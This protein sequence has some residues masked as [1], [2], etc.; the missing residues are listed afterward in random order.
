MLHIFIDADACPVKKE[1]Y[2]VADRYGLAVI[3]V[4]NARMR[5]PRKRWIRLEIVGTRFDA[6]DDWI[7][8]HVQPDDI[9]VSADILLA[10]RCL[11]K[12]ARV[13]GPT[14]K[15]FTEDNIGH[16]VAT[17][18]LLAELREAGEIT[19]GPPPMKKRD[20]SRFLQKLDAVIVSI[21]RG[22]ASNSM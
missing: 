20:R 21:R 19:G 8:E 9:V 6:A 2:R 18:D 12:G 1:V 5:V 16:S 3:L 13:I 4:A 17:R 11:Q 15:L 7:A 10:G 22:Q 14:G